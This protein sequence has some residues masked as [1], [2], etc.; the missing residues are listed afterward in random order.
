VSSVGVAARHIPPWS[1]LQPPQRIHLRGCNRYRQT[2]LEWEEG[3]TVKKESFR[4]VGGRSGVGRGESLRG[5]E[6]AR[7]GG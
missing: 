4:G 1:L 6:N 2:S 5:V 7:L 3:V